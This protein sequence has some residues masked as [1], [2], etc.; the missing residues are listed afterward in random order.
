MQV[1]SLRKKHFWTH[2]TIKYYSKLV[3]KEEENF[4]EEST[5][6]IARY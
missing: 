6:W 3:G 2:V 1:P 4:S 5:M